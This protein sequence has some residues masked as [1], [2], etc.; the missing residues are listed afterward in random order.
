MAAFSAASLSLAGAAWAQAGAP[1]ATART[2]VTEY[3]ISALDKLSI[4]VF[5]V[6]ELTKQE[7]QV[8]STGQFDFPLIGA[9]Q[10][11]G[12]TGRQ[13]AEEITGRLE[14]KYLQDPK[15][16][17]SL[18]SQNAQTITV[19]GAV[20]SPGVFNLQSRTSLLQALAQSKGPT[21][22][23]DERHI[24]VFREI[25]GVRRALIFD[26]ETIRRGEVED[27]PLQANDMVVVAQSKG[28]AAWREIVENVGSFSIFAL[29]R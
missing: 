17:V 22:R 9:V 8:D 13:I 12:R 2:S 7:V 5:G 28:K 15:V 3:R 14:A 21:N 27:P 1:A 29:F 11:A 23:A 24:I 25:G 6:Q 4:T 19:E 26:L 18:I 16:S 10:A 20:T